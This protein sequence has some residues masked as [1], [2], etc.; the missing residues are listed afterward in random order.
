MAEHVLIVDDEPAIVTLLS[1]NLKQ[2]GYEVASASDGASGLVKAISG[3]FAFVILDLML[4]KLDGL[5]I[6]AQI[7]QANQNVAVLILTAKESEE[8]RIKGLELG[9]DDYVTKPFSPREVVARLHAIKRRGK[10]NQ[11]NQQPKTT[12]TS[13][14]PQPSVYHFGELTLDI[15]AY[16]LVDKNGVEIKLTPREF[17]LLAYF[18]K[19]NQRTLSR[20]DLLAGVWGYDYAGQT[21]MVDMHVSHLREKIEPNP[22]VPQYLKTVRGFG[23][24]FDA[25]PADK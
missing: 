21:R 16:K 14:T 23:Y 3:K 15:A 25:T 10:H 6:L 17:K 1:Y 20:D 5:E 7:R 4:P 19:R 12:I 8:D 18:V 9:A 11:T 13:K 24:R 22:K 2:A